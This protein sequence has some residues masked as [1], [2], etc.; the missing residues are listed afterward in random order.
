[1]VEQWTG[2]ATVGIRVEIGRIV[3]HRCQNGRLPD[4]EILG[5][6][7]E[8][9]VTGRL[10]AV[11]TPTEVDRVEVVGEDLLLAHLLGE[12]ASQQHL[13]DLAGDGLLLGQVHDL[14]VLLGDRRPA[15]QAATAGDVHRGPEHARHGVARIGPEGVVLGG[16]N[17]VLDRIRHLVVADRLPVLHL[18][19]AQLGLRVVVIDEA[20]VGGELGVRV[21]DL[22]VL[23]RDRDQ[24]GTGEPTDDDQA[25]QNDEDPPDD[26]SGG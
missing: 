25:E 10:D 13:L 16:D 22:D 17:G 15:L 18:D 9:G 1:L 14:D 23:V 20:G 3:Q 6:L 12:L 24:C 5:V 26:T 2:V 21:R 4:G 11:R 7:V 8:V 19:V